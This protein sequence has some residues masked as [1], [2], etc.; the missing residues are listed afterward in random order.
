M[1]ELAEII[2][3]SR[4]LPYLW[5]HNLGLEKESQR[6]TT[7]GQLAQT[8][9]PSL[10]GKR[11][12]HPY[13]QTDFSESQVEL[14]TPV[15]KSV[16]ELMRW[17]AALHDVI[18]R[19]LPENELLSPLSM[20]PSFSDDLTEIKIARLEKY[21]D[22][23][24]RRYLAKTY[25]K[26]QQMI[27]GIHFNF[28]FDD[29]LLDKLYTVSQTTDSFKTFKNDLYLKVARNYLRYQWL[30]TYLMGASPVANANY[31]S[32]AGDFQGTMRSIRNSIYGYTNHEKLNV[33]YDNLADYV[34]DL[35]K[36]IQQ[37]KIICEKEYYAPV[38]LKGGASLT[39]LL[40]NGIEYIELRNIDLNPFSAYG[41]TNEQIS[42]L[43]ALMVYLAYL[44]E[45]DELNTMEQGNKI[46]K[47]IAAEKPNEVS[48][49]QMLGLQFLAGFEEWIQRINADIDDQVIQQAKLYFEEPKET[50]SARWLQQIHFDQTKISVQ[51]ALENKQEA[52]LKPYQLAGFTTMELSTQ[53]LMFDAIQKGIQVKVLDESEQ[54]IQLQYKGHIEYVKNANMTSKDNYIVPL[55][56][57][58][59]LVTKKVLQTAGYQVPKGIECNAIEEA[60]KYYPKFAQSGFVIKPKSTNFGLGITIFKSGAKEPEYQLA[61]E[62]AFQ[63][64]KTVL[65]EEYVPGTEYRFFVLDGEVK[66]VILREPAN[67]IGD[68]KHTIA[69]LVALKNESPLR[70]SHYQTPLEFI[71]LGEIEQS[72]LAQQGLTVADILPKNQKIFLRVNSNVST[73]GDSIDVTDQ[74]PFE[75]QKVIAAASDALGAKVCGLDVIITDPKQKVTAPGAYSI[76]EANFNPAMHMHAYP[77]KGASHRLT[78]DILKMLYPELE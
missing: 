48:Q 1:S 57:E 55:M 51:F 37:Q 66:S 7:H 61:L 78:M 53:I 50:L 47:I 22:V 5:Q 40:E 4:V 59:K 35:E 32:R 26:A 2:M 77:Y 36:L 75:Y 19:T 23:L 63:Q 70:G 30:I 74:I 24:Y 13:L 6:V 16:S 64:D 67:V 46:S 42:F 18:Y 34:H 41:V 3:D 58:N 71:K 20:P 27:C 38:R 68:G 9:H 56:M 49:Y 76:I 39:E 25:G 31:T 8:N 11:R 72:L 17:L 45:N 14:I 44:P 69:Q 10:L 73:G 28:S 54:F 15:T 65:I 29:E 60:K 43:Q 12:Y 33:S 52:L 21:C 62:R